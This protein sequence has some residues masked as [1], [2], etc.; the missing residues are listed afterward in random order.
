MAAHKIKI[1]HGVVFDA[2]KHAIG[3]SLQC[4]YCGH[5][6]GEWRGLK[7]HIQRMSC[8]ALM[9][10]QEQPILVHPAEGVPE[11]PRVTPPPARE[12]EQIALLINER[13]CSLCNRW[14]RNPTALKRRLK[15]THVDLWV[16]V[17]P[18]LES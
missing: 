7:M 1:T 11:A 17:E 8:H 10:C 12:E 14:I 13:R 18:R 15:Q 6:F 4:A 9:Q 16:Q 3:N 2:A 5:K